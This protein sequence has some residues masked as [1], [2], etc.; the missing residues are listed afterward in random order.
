[1]WAEGREKD[2]RFEAGKNLVQGKW[3]DC[4]M[5]IKVISEVKAGLW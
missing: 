1:M 3:G 4:L 5:R 2:Q